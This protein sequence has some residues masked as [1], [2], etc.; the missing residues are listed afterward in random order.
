[1]TWDRKNICNKATP[2]KCLDLDD[3]S[4]QQE[5]AGWILYLLF[6]HPYK[7]GG[8]IVLAIRERKN[9]FIGTFGDQAPFFGYF[10]EEAPFYWE[11][12]GGVFLL[13]MLKLCWTLAGFSFYSPCSTQWAGH[14]EQV[15]LL[16]WP[17]N[18][19]EVCLNNSSLNSN[20]HVIYLYRLTSIMY[21]YAWICMKPLRMCINVQLV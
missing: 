5:L 20:R 16:V 4:G 14:L 6:I 2:I 21:L 3:T 8:T 17:I 1:M 9:N 18:T 7:W 11:E 10:R 13:T 19:W 12:V 15:T